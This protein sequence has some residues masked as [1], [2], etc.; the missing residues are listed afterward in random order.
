MNMTVL[1]SRAEREIVESTKR[2]NIKYT[3]VVPVT[4]KNGSSENKNT[5]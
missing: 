4:K 2:L 1:M 5:P 3:L